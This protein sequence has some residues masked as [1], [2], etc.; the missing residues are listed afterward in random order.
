MNQLKKINYSQLDIKLGQFMEEEL[1]I[2]L[3]KIKSRK[4]EGYICKHRRQESLTTCFFGYATVN[5][6]NTI[7]KR[8]KLL[9]LKLLRFI[10]HSFSTVSNLKLRKFFG[11]IRTVFEEINPNFTVAEYP[12][13][14]Q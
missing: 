7:E 1:D 10:I 12:L 11:K 8:R 3:K 14:H 13:N 4:V 2:L 6:Q 5:K 9:L